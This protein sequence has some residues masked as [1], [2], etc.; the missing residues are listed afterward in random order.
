MPSLRKIAIGNHFIFEDKEWKNNKAYETDEPE[1][2]AVAMNMDLVSTTNATSVSNTTTGV[3]INAV[4]CTRTTNTIANSTLTPTEPA[5]VMAMELR[6]PFQKQILETFP[7]LDQLEVCFSEKSIGSELASL[8]RSTCSEFRLLTLTGTQQPWTESM[9][10]GMPDAVEELFLN[11]SKL[12][13][14]MAS[15]TNNRRSKLTQV[16]LDFGQTFKCKQC[17]VDTII[18]S[19]TIAFDAALLNHLKDLRSPSKVAV[20]ETAYHKKLE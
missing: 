10:K 13:H 3:G 12:G 19:Q 4:A 14:V 5:P 7:K 15:F 17:L 2:E 16:E 8:M 1:D 6:Q 9:I 20:T 18:R 11:T